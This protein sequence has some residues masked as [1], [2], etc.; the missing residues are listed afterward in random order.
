[1]HRKILA[2]AAAA[3]TLL[4]PAAA[5]AHV[6]LQPQEVAAGGFTRMDV[7]VP[8]ERD[9][10]GTTKVAVKMPPGFIFA[11]YESYPG[12]TVEVEK[13]KLDKPVEMF[14]EEQTEE[15]DT[16]TW[17]GD[18]ERGIVKPGEFKDFGLSVGVPEGKPG[19]KLKFAATQSYEGGEVVRW[20][21]PEDADEPAPLVT[22]KAAAG[23]HGGSDPTANA[24]AIVEENDAAPA[25]TSG[26]S[27]DALDDKAS[28]GLAIGALVVGALGLLVGIAGFS[29]ARRRSA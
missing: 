8:N 12:W 13:R 6:T 28:K 7:R 16:I 4:A 22:L 3:A 15:V 23:E 10:K 26:V 27:P 25:Q 5:S 2:A 1:M 9:D 20:I 21:G 18:G 11:S 24:T 29:A 17:T 14:G 19:S